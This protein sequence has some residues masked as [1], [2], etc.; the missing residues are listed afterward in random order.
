[1]LGNDAVNVEK[2]QVEGVYKEEQTI[3]GLN[4]NTRTEHASLPGRRIEK[5]AHLLAHPAFDAESKCLTLRQLQ[6]FRGIATGWAVVVKGLKNELKAADVFLTCGDGSLPIRPRTLG[7]QNE[8][9]AAIKAWDDLWSLFEVCRWLCARPEMWEA[10]FGATLN[11]LLEPRE[12][13][14]MPGGH[15][16]AVFV[17]ADATPT[18]VGAIDWTGGFAAQLKAE[19]MG[20]WLQQALEDEKEDWQIRIHV[21]EMLAFTA[22]AVTQGHRWKGKGRYLCWGQHCGAIV[23]HQE[24]E[25]VQGRTTFSFGFWP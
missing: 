17:S 20:P 14:G 6:Q 25:R 2:N 1:M 8:E 24:T 22:F 11:E 13:L 21:S 7:Y 3:W 10:Q 16:H 5:G 23:D 4:I 12:R 19:D 18:T 9:Q 15:H